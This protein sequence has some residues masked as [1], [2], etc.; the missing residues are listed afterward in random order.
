MSV[1]SFQDTTRLS[2][3]NKSIQ[4]TDDRVI[5]C[6]IF[7][8][9]ISERFDIQGPNARECCDMLKTIL[10]D[11]EASDRPKRIVDAVKEIKNLIRNEISQADI[12]NNNNA[13]ITVSCSSSH[14]MRRLLKALRG[15]DFQEGVGKL[16]KAL[17]ETYNGSIVVQANIEIQKFGQ[18]LNSFRMFLFKLFVQNQSSYFLKPVDM[19]KYIDN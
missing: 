9:D 1:K 2:K 3:W 7:I 8:L 5:Y 12:E 15:D 13:V 6:H 11:E 16:T 10:E 18:V 17:G 14:E 4:D 19:Y